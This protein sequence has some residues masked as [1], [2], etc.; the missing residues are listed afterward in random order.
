M[1]QVIVD[2]VQ[3]DE[4]PQTTHGADAKGRRLTRTIVVVGF[5]L[6]AALFFLLLFSAPVED[7]VR[8]ALGPVSLNTF[9]MWL[10]NLH[11]LLQIPVVLAVFG[12]V[13]AVLLVLIE[14]A[15]RPGR[16]YF[17]MRLVAC[18]VIPLLAFMML[19]PYANAVFYVVAIALLS[20]ALLFFADYRSRQ[21]PAT[22]SSSSSSWP[23][24]R[25]CCCWV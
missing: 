14:Y 11:P 19:R 21:G 10:G 16:G 25:S 15:P 12:A 24:H 22:C 8:I 13:V 18:L 23:R 3:T 4:L 1:S 20:G 5:V 9:F 7:P 2:D 17:I 6:I